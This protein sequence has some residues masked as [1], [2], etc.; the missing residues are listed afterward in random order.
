MVM[1]AAHV[2]F[3]PIAHSVAV[4]VIVVHHGAGVRR[5][6]LPYGAGL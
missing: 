6:G 2:V 4:V 1:V 5:R 3:W